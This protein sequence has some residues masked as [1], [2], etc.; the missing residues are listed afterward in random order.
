MIFGWFASMWRDEGFS[1][2]EAGLLVGLVAATAIAAVAVGADPAGQVG[3]PAMAAVRDPGVLP[4]RVRRD[5]GRAAHGRGRVGAVGRRRATT[6]PLVLTLV[7]LRR[8][9][10]G[11][12]A[13]SGVT[14]S[15]G[16]LI[17][18]AGP[19]SFGALHDATGGWT[20]PCSC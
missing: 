14:Q 12:A 10:E 7:G 18:A 17:A 15:V 3:G 6:F 13:L 9:T 1:A 20:W 11:T 5:P 2:A 4:R 16:Y 19:F 8:T